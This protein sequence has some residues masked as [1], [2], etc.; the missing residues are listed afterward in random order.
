MSFVCE[1]SQVEQGRVASRSLLGGH[2]ARDH[3]LRNVRNHAVWI[4]M[5]ACS[6]K[7]RSHTHDKDKVT[8]SKRRLVRSYRVCGERNG[9]CC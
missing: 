2:V 4:C 3:L 9:V 8:D 1:V 7:N 6:K 5:R